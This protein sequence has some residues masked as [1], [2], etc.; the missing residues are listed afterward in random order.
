MIQPWA[1]QPGE[2]AKAYAAFCVYRDQGGERTI[3]GSWM[4]HTGQ[5]EEKKGKGAPGYF[6]AW[7]KVNNWKERAHL[8][9][10][11][12]DEEKRAQSLKIV[13]RAQTR[14]QQAA[15][16]LVESSIHAAL[17]GNV[18]AA[19]GKILMELLDRAGLASIKGLNVNVS[20]DLSTGEKLGDIIER[21]ETA[22]TA[23]LARA[24]FQAINDTG[25]TE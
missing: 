3:E 1:R 9:D 21:I 16:E 2:T 17:S 8:Y 13:T 12:L 23:E 18:H 19:Q 22:T 7:Y 4:A 25:E 10:D 24:Y 20:G 5:P 14:L 6:V 15:I 11:F